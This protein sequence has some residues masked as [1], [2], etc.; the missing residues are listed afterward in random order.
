MTYPRK[1]GVG[2]RT[3]E[4]RRAESPP[5]DIP[6]WRERVR[7]AQARVFFARIIMAKGRNRFIPR[8]GFRLDG[9]EK[10]IFGMVGRA[11]SDA[12]CQGIGVQYVARRRKNCCG[13]FLS[14]SPEESE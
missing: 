11:Q 14:C 12:P 1:G 8:G 5:C 7:R 6:G 9:F 13:I 3:S 10:I 2:S 4:V